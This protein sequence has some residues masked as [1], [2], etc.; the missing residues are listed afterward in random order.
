MAEVSF[1][2]RAAKT[3]RYELASANTLRVMSVDDHPLLREGIATIIN[4]QTDM[5]LIS[6]VATGAEG[7]KSF[8]EL[9]PDVTLVDLRLPDLSGIEVISA[10]RAQNPGARLIVLTTFEGDVEIQRA[11][12]AG[13]SGYLLKNMPAKQI[14][15]TVRA[16]HVGRR[17]IPPQIAAHIAEHLAEESLSQR[18]LEV[19]RHVA[20]GNRN[21]DIAELLHI[22]EE[23]VKVHL[24]HVMEKLGASDRTQAVA[25]AVRRGIM[26]L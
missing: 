23:T 8:N 20:E 16:V 15:D 18:E 7:I 22:S 2:G 4:N 17:V 12:K 24:K 11:L 1:A 25:I 19:L 26:H 3:G 13:A 21:R 14:V 10:I 9:Q 5:T 6:S